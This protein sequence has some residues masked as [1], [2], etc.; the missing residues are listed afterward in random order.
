MHT[1]P[2]GKT[3]SHNHACFGGVPVNNWSAVSS[4]K[5]KRGVEGTQLLAA[6]AAG[7]VDAG[8]FSALP[9]MAFRRVSYA[10]CAA[11][12]AVTVGLYPAA[13]AARASVPIP[14]P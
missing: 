13:C 2:A 12:S 3:P 1:L 9:G 6:C 14:I 7:T 4:A 8:G 10:A 5:L 11:D